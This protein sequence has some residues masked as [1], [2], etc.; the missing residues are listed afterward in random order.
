[1]KKIIVSLVILY[2]LSLNTSGSF[3][4]ETCAPSVSI[5]PIKEDCMSYHSV[6]AVRFFLLEDGL[7]KTGGVVCKH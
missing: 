7:I 4:A 2:I 6:I 1:M 5:D 3:L